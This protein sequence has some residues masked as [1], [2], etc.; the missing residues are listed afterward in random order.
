MTIPTASVSVWFGRGRGQDARFLTEWRAAA[1]NYS[2]GSSLDRFWNTDHYDIVLGNDENGDLFK[3][4]SDLLMHNRFYPPSVMEFTGD[5][6]LANRPVQAGDRVV[7]RVRILTIIGFPILE[8]LTMNEISRVI[9]EVD[10][11]G[12][13][14]VTTLVHSE[15]GEW[16]PGVERHSDGTVHL[17]ID[18]ISRA[19][20]E[21]SPRS[22]AFA[23]R[24][25]LRAHHLSIE[26][27]R[28]LL[29]T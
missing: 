12:F 29:N 8:I 11:K 28:Q 2:A 13:T 5:F 19:R 9:D 22:R 27:F 15:I 7:Q 16:S 1:V 18:V 26:N 17:R 6:S 3:R 4:A 24:L 23:R 14:Y 20:P 10:R 25:Q 21:M